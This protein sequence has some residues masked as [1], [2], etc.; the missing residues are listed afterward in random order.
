MAERQ[1]AGTGAAILVFAVAFAYFALFVHYGLNVDDEGTLLAE[2][3]RTFRGELPYRDFHMGYTPLGHYFQAALFRCFGVSVVPLRWALAVCH[4]LVAM[5]LFAIGRRVMPTAFA[6]LAPAVYVAIIP[7]YP[8]EFASFNIPYPA[9]WVVLFGVAGF[10]ALLRYQETTHFGWLAASGVLTGVSLGFKPNVGLFQF[11]AA[12]LV[13]L[14]LLEPPA[15]GRASRWQVALWWLLAAGISGGLAG[16]F[17]SQAST[18]DVGIFLLPVIAVLVVLAARRI[19]GRS[20]DVPSH[21]LFATGV[22]FGLAT[23]AAIVPWIVVFIRALGRQRFMRLVLFIGAGFERYYYVPF[24]YA[25]PWDS[26]LVVAVI[27]AACLG[28]LAR[29]RRL[30]R[31][32]FFAGAAIGGVGA[33]IALW[34]ADMPEGLHAAVVSRTEDLSFTAT[35]VVHWAAL[36]TMLPVLWSRRRTPRELT[37][38]AILI[39]AYSMYLQLYP[40]SDFMHVIAAVPLTLV[41]GAGL[42]AGLAAAMAETPGLGAPARVL[43]I[44]GTLAFAAFRVVPNLGAIATWE[45]GPAWRQLATLDLRGAPLGLE[46]GRWP[47]LRTLHDAATY[48]NANTAEG[49]AVFTFPA[50]ELVAFLADRPQATRRG[51]FFPAWP[52]HDVEAEVVDALAAAPPRL[53]VVL[54]AH[55][56]FFVGAPAYYYA[57]REFLAARYRQV[58]Q[59]GDYAVLARH[60][61]PDEALHMPDGVPD[62]PPGVDAWSM[63]SSASA[64]L[65]ARYGDALRGLPEERLAAA[66][67]LAA[68]RL[69]Y[70]WPPVAA[71]LDDP[72]PRIRGA[73]L[74]ALAGAVDPGVAV[75]LARAL[76]QGAVPASMR[77]GALRRISA[78]ADG[79]VIRPLLEML[80]DLIDLRERQLVLSALDGIASKLAISDYWLGDRRGFRLSPLD[81]PGRRK[82]RAMLADSGEDARVRFFLAWVLPRLGDQRSIPALYVTLGSNWPVL[83]SAA[84]QGLV[85]LHA[86]PRFD[87]LDRLL[88]YVGSEPTFAPSIALEMYHRDKAATRRTLRAA[89]ETGPLLDQAPIAW[90]M[91]ATGDRH[92]R[93]DYLRLLHIPIRELRLAA[94]AGLTRIADPRTRAAIEPATVD[95]D[96]AIRE[97]AERASAATRAARI[98]PGAVE[99]IR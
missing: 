50:I 1:G 43:L 13:L 77:L 26:A 69:D 57:L 86:D 21:G 25:G 75:P 27:A 91:A 12:G 83:V 4:S 89:L 45:H 44:G 84:V 54:H 68:D 39:G 14:V 16:V 90:L 63:S 8:G 10:W 71:L 17:G 87:L 31:T 24:H 6:V 64:A 97:F 3:Y 48:V 22:V 9:W 23:A 93:G 65:E 2:F 60:D 88:T 98:N 53:V 66:T 80:P 36:A 5:L 11:A 94:L 74:Q 58:A 46:L 72:D 92:F 15:D 29:A 35:L 96:F 41:L 70:P 49:E 7:F 32:L 85:R 34:R 42:A 30:P 61:V 56:F 78:S 52:G 59:F 33:A 19:A 37:S 62:T 81:V 82:W 73:A 79:R 95:P 40:R 99:P 20:A 76:L 51:H 18:R 47:R 38:L 67:Q 28:F 55:Q